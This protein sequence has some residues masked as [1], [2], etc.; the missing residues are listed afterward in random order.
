MEKFQEKLV[1]QNRMAAFVNNPVKNIAKSLELRLSLLVAQRNLAFSLPQE[2][3]RIF[4]KELPN[5]PD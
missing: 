2:I 5:N 4:K 1:E 3:I